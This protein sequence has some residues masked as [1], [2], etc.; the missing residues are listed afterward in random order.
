[1]PDKRR[2][3]DRRA[4]FTIEQKSNVLEKR[5]VATSI[6]NLRVAQGR[7]RWERYVVTKGAEKLKGYFQNLGTGDKR[8][9]RSGTPGF[10][11]DCSGFMDERAC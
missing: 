6:V 4:L 3:T 9:G 11:S 1:M 7:V 10:H 8:V 5:N 2:Q